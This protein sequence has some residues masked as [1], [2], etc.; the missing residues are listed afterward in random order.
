MRRSTYLGIILLSLLALTAVAGAQT[1]DYTITLNRTYGG[2]DTGDAAYAIVPDPGGAGFFLAGGTES[3]G[4]G[5]TDAWVV[6]LNPEGIDEWNRTYGGEE[7]DIARSIIRTNDGGLLVAGNLTYVTNGTRPDTD[8]WLV[9]INS[10]GDEAWNRTY[11]GPDVNTSANAVTVAGDGGYLFVGSTTAWGGNNSDAWAVRVNETGGEVW[12]RVLGGTGNDTAN[13]VV[14]LPDGDFVLA[15]S[16]ASSGAGMADVWVIRL[17]ES[18]S[19]VWN[20]T[21]GSPDV[22]AGRA[23]V[24]TPDG[25]LLVAGT[26]TERPD[27]A[28]VDTDA[29]LIKLTPAGDL[30]WNWIYGDFGVNES[31]AVVIAAED[32]GY[33]FAGETGFLGTDDTD[34]WV[35]GTDAAGAVAW[36]RT[37][38]GANPGDRA[39]SLIE[40]VPGEY[41]VAG[42]FNA[43]GEEG[44]VNTD[45]WLIRLAIPPEPTPTPTPTPAPTPTPTAVPIKPP[46]APPVPQ[47]TP[48][49]TGPV[50]TP[51]AE[52][53]IPPAPTPTRTV[54]PGP[55][56]TIPPAPTIP[57]PALT[58][59]ATPTRTTKPTHEPTMSPTET[60]GPTQIATATPTRTA[61]PTYEPTMFPTSKPAKTPKPT[62]TPDKDDDDDNDDNHDD[63]DNG[64]DNGDDRGRRALSGLVWYDLNADGAPGPGEPGIPGISVR[65][66]GRRT[67]IDSAVTGPDGSYRFPVVSVEDVAGAEFLVPDGYSCTVPGLGSD[68]TPLDGLVAFAE[69]GVDRQTLNAG[70]I[71]EYRAETPA[72]AYGWV[73]G[74]VWGDGNQD[75]INDEAYGMTDVEVR[76]LDAEG[77]M[78]ASARTGYHDRYTSLYL[79]GPLLPGEYAVAFTPPDGYT[80]TTAGGDSSADP[81]T[82][83]TGPFT[84][85]GGD[86]VTRDAGLISVLTP[87]PTQTPP[88]GEGGDEG[89]PE[90]ESAGDG[91]DARDLPLP[92]SEGALP[93]PVPD[94]PI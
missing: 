5:K 58:A 51:T 3:F 66:I 13:A 90:N 40:A 52:V 7:D 30:I 70:F 62:K 64:D 71:G 84:V 38:G 81:T 12:N 16:T 78:L 44:P 15:G 83:S 77:D 22:D 65:L 88:A 60:P 54:R 24:N 69:G 55:D 25:G 27:N 76:L 19:E 43:T 23:V 73:L 37:A 87:S 29:L 26:F 91:G 82:G 14:R 4:S 21:F 18:G 61:Q 8:A 28:T 47:K 10:S 6:R 89:S 32:G 36:S 63:D 92:M 68:A 11:G 42:T 46:K 41:A 56:V 75:G 94:G 72:D 93:L 74:T 1:G 67:M 33:V 85:A 86:V 50:T 53:I 31:A 80:F 49:I 9:K 2:P 45:A 79:F 17:N 59:T 35:V 39:A 20:R 34:A 57:G 48:A